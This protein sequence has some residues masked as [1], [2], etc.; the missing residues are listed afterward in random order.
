MRLK[1]ERTGRVGPG[2]CRIELLNWRSAPGAC[3]AENIGNLVWQC[4]I[5]RV[6]NHV[7]NHVTTQ[8]RQGQAGQA[9]YRNRMLREETVKLGQEKRENPV[10]SLRLD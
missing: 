7:A 3:K 1:C 10:V 2:P 9:L 6:T 5:S 4:T 8:D